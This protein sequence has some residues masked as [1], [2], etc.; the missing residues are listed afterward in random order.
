MKKTQKRL[1]KNIH[2]KHIYSKNIWILFLN[3]CET[4]PLPW[5]IATYSQLIV[6]II[7]HILQNCNCEA[8]LMTLITY[9][10]STR[11]PKITFWGLH[12]IWFFLMFL[13]YYSVTNSCTCYLKNWI[14]RQDFQ[15]CKQIDYWQFLS[16]FW[17]HSSV[18]IAPTPLT[19]Q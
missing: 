19:T 8:Y 11:V 15:S 10:Y 14:C 18:R 3:E 6:P 12:V 13:P 9:F 5:F 2:S 17:W 1:R 4:T 16:A 7:F